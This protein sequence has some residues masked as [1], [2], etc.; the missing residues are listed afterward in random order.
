ML[1][2][3]LT[4]SMKSLLRLNEELVSTTRTKNNHVLHPISNIFS[5]RILALKLCA[6]CRSQCFC[7]Q[8]PRLGLAKDISHLLSVLR[9]AHP[10]HI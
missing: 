10:R 2:H 7:I 1:Q 4:E 6:L 5:L 3:L 8:R 9:Q